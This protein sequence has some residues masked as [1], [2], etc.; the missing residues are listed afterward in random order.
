VAALT[1]E[2]RIEAA[3]DRIRPAIRRDGGDVWLIKVDDAV[4]YVQMIGACGGCPDRPEQRS[5]T[6][7]DLDSELATGSGRRNRHRQRVL[8]AANTVAAQLEQPR[9]FNFPHRPGDPIA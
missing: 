8:G 3:L 7:I 6:Q 9:R 4:A 5:A 1:V 2:N